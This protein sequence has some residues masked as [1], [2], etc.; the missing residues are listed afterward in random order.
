MPIENIIIFS[1]SFETDKSFNRL[2]WTL[3]K[4]HEKK[5]GDKHTIDTDQTPGAHGT[6]QTNFKP[7]VDLQMIKNIQESQNKIKLHNEMVEY[8]REHGE[9]NRVRREP[10]TPLKRYL[11]V[12]D[13]LVGDKSWASFNSELANF[14]L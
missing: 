9:R 7:F 13:D 8:S 12:V 2:R 1:P 6:I 14:C 11:I 3:R 10:I 4:L 5:S